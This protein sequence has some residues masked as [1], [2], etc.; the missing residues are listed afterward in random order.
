[1]RAVAVGMLAALVASFPARAQ[2]DPQRKAEAQAQ[3]QTQKARPARPAVLA[4]VTRFDRCFVLAGE[5]YGVSPLLLKAVARQ[6]SGLNP[7]AVNRNANGSTDIGL[8]Q[9]NSS[10]LPTLE[11]HGVKE[12]D[13]RVPCANILVGAWILGSNFRAM[14][15][16]VDALGAYNARDPVKRQAYARQVLRH[17][18]ALNEGPGAGLRA[19]LLGA[20]RGAES[21]QAAQATQ[22]AEATAAG[23]VRQVR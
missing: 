13:L 19:G 21:A 9:I 15:R 8:M 14:G 18:V 5:R 10:W 2:Q 4:D 1:M 16:T 17:Y 22:A 3:T 6:E 12:N 11:R 23:S 7:A 20:G